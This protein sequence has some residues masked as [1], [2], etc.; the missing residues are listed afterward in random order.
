MGEMAREGPITIVRIMDRLNVGGPALHAVFT[1]KGMDPQRFRTVLVHG[2]VEPGEGDMKY[3]LR[4]HGIHDTVCIPSLGRELRPLKDLVT[5][6]KLIAVLLRERPSVVHTHKAK[7][8]A[9]G[10][11]AAFLCRV[12][13][14]VHTFHG[15]VLSGYFG[16]RKSQLFAA[17]ER[18]LA[19]VTTAIVTPSA[20]VADELHQRFA[21]APRERFVPVSLGFDLQPFL[22]NDGLRGQLRQELGVA[23]P[24]RLIGIVGRMVPVKDHATFIAAAAELAARQP[25]V[26]FV[27]VG[28]GELEA[29]VRQE[30]T[31]RGLGDRAHLLGWRQDMARIY[32]DMDVLA[33]SSLNE[34]T[35]VTLIE[36]MAS[37]VP[38]VA[39]DVGGVKDVLDHGRRGEIVPPRDATALANAMERALLPA[40]RQRAHSQRAMV[41]EE[42]GWQRLCQDLERLY[43]RHLPG[44]APP[45]AATAP[46]PRESR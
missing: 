16:P 35:P 45:L 13:V 25:D 22:N 1:T 2:E 7:A 29:Q 27:F 6:A 37:G 33:L 3:L 17:M 14:R 15:H 11:V 24:I 20:A 30:L 44:A 34:G 21:I 31:R 38:V 9:L 43:L 46:S 36:A 32:A 41:A 26:A 12:P 5:L 39:T 23:A 10:R 19:K 42:Y 40:A 28:A 4:E 18:A 8:G